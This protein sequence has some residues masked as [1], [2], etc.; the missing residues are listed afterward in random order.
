MTAGGAE[1]LL[2]SEKDESH[3]TRILKFAAGR[4][5]STLDLKIKILQEFD[6]FEWQVRVKITYILG[7]G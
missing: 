4:K 2:P 7:R 3:V 1:K 6:T 5:A